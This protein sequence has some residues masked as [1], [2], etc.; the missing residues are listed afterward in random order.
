MV[1][2]SFG[3]QGE[4]KFGKSERIPQ[5]VVKSILSPKPITYLDK[6]GFAPYTTKSDPI[7]LETGN[8]SSKTNLKVDMYYTL[9]IFIR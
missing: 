1:P 3:G 9:T 8:R 2:P 4:H 7:T 6:F 5:N